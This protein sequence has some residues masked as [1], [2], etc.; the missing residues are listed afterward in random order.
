[1][2]VSAIKIGKQY[3]F[4]A[5]RIKTVNDIENGHVKWTEDKG[6]SGHCKVESFANKALSEVRG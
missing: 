5:G 6:D 2:K 3:V 4:R 1:M